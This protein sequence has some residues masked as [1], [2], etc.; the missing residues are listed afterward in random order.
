MNNPIEVV[1][2]D[3]QWAIQFENEA[4]LIKQALGENCLAVHHIGSTSVLG[5]A[6]K[7]RIDIIAVVRNSQSAWS[8][9]EK[10]GY[11]GRGELNI[12]FRSYFTKRETIPEINLHVYEEGNAE[13]E[14][15]ILF[16]DYL[17][18][19]PE[20]C[21]E[22]ENLKFSL[23]SQES[24]HERKNA[25]F[26]GYN[27]GKDAFI[28][29]ILKQTGFNGLCMRFCTHYDEWEAARTLRQRYFFDKISIAD[30]YTWTFDHKDHVHFVLYQGPDI[31]GYLQIQLWPAQRAALRIIVI[32]E[33]YRTQ[34]KGGEFLE[35]C[36][37]WLKQQS[38][39]VLQTESSPA[40]CNF[41]RKHGYSEM[42]FNDPEGNETHPNDTAMGKTL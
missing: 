11:Q 27:L 40:A 24:S 26:K 36:E 12:P 16:R 19:H 32:D 6:A 15:N 3:G 33:P 18:K 30:P 20:A 4:K 2:Y 38:F 21:I 17:R 34:G 22:Y 14:L 10:T 8:S 9:L 35:R 39:Q 13:I 5:L 29:K 31:I 28:K 1:T 42:P 25:F 7:P 37:R 23:L 41:Y